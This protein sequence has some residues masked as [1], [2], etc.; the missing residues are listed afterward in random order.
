MDLSN[1]F[2]PGGALSRLFAANASAGGQPAGQS[3]PPQPATAAPPTPAAPSLPTAPPSDYATFIKNLADAAAANIHMKTWTQRGLLTAANGDDL[4]AARANVVA[5]APQAYDAYQSGHTGV[6]SGQ[7]DLGQNLA[8]INNWRLAHGQAPV[9][10]NNLSGTFYGP[11]ATTKPFGVPTDAMDARRVTAPSDAPATDDRIALLTGLADAMPTMPGA[12]PQGATPFAPSLQPPVT[13]APLAPPQGTPTGSDLNALFTRVANSMPPGMPQMTAPVAAQP[14]GTPAPANNPLDAQRR[15][16]GSQAA[17]M[18]GLPKFSGVLP[19]VLKIANQ[20]NPDGTQTNLGT[21]QVSD[22]IN[23]RPESGSVGELLAGRAG[24]VAAAQEIPRVVGEQ[25]ID[26]NK[27]GQE[28]QTNA[29]RI[30]SEN[31]YKPPTLMRAP[32]GSIVGV[33][34]MQMAE[35]AR[36]GALNGYRPL[37]EEDTKALG[38]MGETYVKEQASL[39]DVR[40][41]QAVIHRMLDQADAFPTGTFGEMKQSAGRLLVGLG[42]DPDQIAKVIG[43]PAS[44]DALVKDSLSLA[45]DRLRQSFGQAREAGFV[46][47]MTQKANPGIETQPEAFRLMLNSLDQEAQRQADYLTTQQQYRAQHGSIDGFTEA[48]DAARPVAAYANTAM[49][50]TFGA[51]AGSRFLG[52]SQGKPVFQTPDGKKM[53]VTH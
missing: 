4:T 45:M 18:G 34:P 28:R 21:G 13:V 20:G 40:R 29:A 43:N 12:S 49:V 32:D 33:T 35:A 30:A 14:G 19:E 51:P 1:L 48:F 27:A 6:Q 44:A 52:R 23:G 46:L 5:G 39:P 22:V 7:L 31:A 2:A 8:F 11:T 50:N 42:A 37:T 17:A 41:T 47:A 36:T 25:L 16:F 53:M 10:V 26:N 3:N 9:D 15:F 38:S 24:R